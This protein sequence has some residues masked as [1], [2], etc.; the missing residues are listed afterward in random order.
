MAMTEFGFEKSS[1]TAWRASARKGKPKSDI[2][3]HKSE[4]TGLQTF[5]SAFYTEQADF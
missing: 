2:A 5:F 1:P 3:S 4:P